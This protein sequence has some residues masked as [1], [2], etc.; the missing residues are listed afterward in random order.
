MQIY[1]NDN[2]ICYA[3]SPVSVEFYIDLLSDIDLAKNY[4]FIYDLLIDS[5]SQH[6]IDAFPFDLFADKKQKAESQG[7]SFKFIL[8][9]P[10][11]APTYRY[12][13]SELV[14]VISDRFDIPTTDM[15]IMTGAQHQWDDPIKNCMVLGIIGAN[16]LFEM[17]VPSSEPTHHFISL[18]R[19][20]KKHRVIA[21]KMIWDKGLDKFGFCSLGCLE[22]DCVD[23]ETIKVWLGDHYRRYPS[24]LD[25]IVGNGFNNTNEANL[26]YGTD[27]RIG[28]AFS[29][30]VLETSYDR[31]I[32]RNNWNVPFMTEKTTKPFLWNQVPIFVAAK[33]SLPLMRQVGYD[34][35]DDI[36]DHSYDNEPNPYKR[37]ELAI[38]QLEKICLQPIEVWK[39]YRKDNQHRFDNNRQKAL[40]LFYK[41]R[42]VINRKNL[43]AVLL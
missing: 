13:C 7:L 28:N 35:F 33:G 14:H 23:D 22:K 11:E 24:L 3:K 30:L 26:N 12:Q 29:N 32:T 10:F 19:N 4:I 43:E 25:G 16:T 1:E 27:P 38:D 8:G 41:E 39:Q 21:T 15:I 37:I 40:D 42:F 36:I 5:W 20:S 2:Y 31:S 34:L 9:H 17:P 18:A 6:P